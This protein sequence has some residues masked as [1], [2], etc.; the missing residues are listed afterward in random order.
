MK[1]L[2]VQEGTHLSL[3]CIGKIDT[4]T[5][6]EFRN[7]TSD[8]DFSLFDSVVLDFENVPYI[9]SAGLRELLIIKKKLKADVPLRISNASE[10]VFNIFET[11]GF[12][13]FLELEHKQNIADYSDMSFGKFLSFKRENDIGK[14]ILSFAGKSYT[15]TTID[16]GA[17]AVAEELYKLGVRKGDHVALCGTNSANWVF[18]FYAIQKLGG[19]C[20]LLN[21]QLTETEIKTFS[22]A[23]DIDYLCYGEMPQ[24]PD[25]SAV[26]QD[27]TEECAIKK[28][29]N[30]KNCVDFLKAAP[31]SYSYSEAVVRPDDACVMVFTSGSTGVPKGAL[32]SAYNILSASCSNVESLRITS[33]DRACLILPM[34]HIFGLVA[35]LCANAIADA[36][37]LIPD[38]IRTDT[39]IR[40]VDE[41]QCTIMHSVPT[42]LLAILNNKDFNP[43]KLGSLRSTILSGAATTEA[44]MHMFRELFP[45]N[46]FASSYGMSEMAPISITDYDDTP[47]HICHTV[48]KPIKNIHVRIYDKEAQEECETGKTG[49]IQVHGFNL[50]TCYYK[51][52][53]DMQSINADGWMSTGDLGS[54]DEEGYIHFVGRL[55][56]LI[57]RGGENIIPNEIVSALC[58]EDCISDA[59]V[60]GVPDDFF[61]ERVAAAIILSNPLN[62]NEEQLRQNLRSKLAK[63]K[64]PDW[65]I[66]YDSFPALSNGKVD[67]VRLKSEIIQKCNRL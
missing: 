60:F 37:M 59:K 3:E 61:G 21:P 63:F 66:V 67:S 10:E 22:N 55:K 35:G 46:H 30:I 39:V 64:I 5:A 38:N 26:A 2:K 29:L 15:W 56:E 33:E 53:L 14:T 27:I 58:S 19:I 11:T 13:S 36:E 41:N 62:F 7:T 25:M 51:A 8:I 28:F 32:L 40:T 65:F 45:N 57:I 20:L 44:Q 6:P 49:E 24:I 31:S 34:F 43:G 48:G 16:S 12:T 17:S 42:L 4:S 9:S 47:E 50:M 54:L 23:G 52:Q 18:T 1:L